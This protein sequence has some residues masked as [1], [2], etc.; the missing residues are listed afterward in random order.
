[1][2]K[3]QALDFNKIWYIHIASSPQHNYVHF[4][5][6]AVVVAAQITKSNIAFP[7]ITNFRIVIFLP[8][9]S[10]RACSADAQFIC[11]DRKSI[12]RGAPNNVHC[13]PLIMNECK[14]WQPRPM[15]MHVAFCHDININA[16]SIYYYMPLPLSNLFF[17]FTVSH[18]LISVGSAAWPMRETNANFIRRQP[19]TLKWTIISIAI[20]YAGN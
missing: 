17:L 20:S 14:R 2:E 15:F 7:F 8:A 9:L 4:F 13:M 12:F 1:M 3:C 11:K 16:H 5:F 19:H 18:S 6:V 10:V